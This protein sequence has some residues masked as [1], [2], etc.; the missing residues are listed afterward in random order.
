MGGKLKVHLKLK[1][2]YPI[3]VFALVKKKKKRLEKIILFLNF[4]FMKVSTVMT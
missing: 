3:F 1:R 4:F 2:F